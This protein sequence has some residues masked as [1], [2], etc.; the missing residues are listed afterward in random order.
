MIF[1]TTKEAI[2]REI[3]QS[4]LRLNLL[5]ICT[6]EPHT[7]HDLIHAPEYPGLSFLDPVGDKCVRGAW[8]A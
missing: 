7:I 8:G 6:R 1:L 4:E 5:R 2:R 3:A